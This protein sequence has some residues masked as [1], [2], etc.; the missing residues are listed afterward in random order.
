MMKYESTEFAKVS[1]YF[2]SALITQL[3]EE[4]VDEDLLLNIEEEICID[5]ELEAL[6]A[7]VA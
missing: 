4:P 5:A 3:F 1:A 6:L 2:R 7:E